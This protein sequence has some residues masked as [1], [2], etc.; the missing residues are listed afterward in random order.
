MDINPY[1]N[2]IHQLK[3]FLNKKNK[4]KMLNLPSNILWKVSTF[5]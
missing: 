3:K 5:S 2:I 1:Y 4:E